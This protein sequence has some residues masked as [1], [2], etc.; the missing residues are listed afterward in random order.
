VNE[1]PDDIEPTAPPKL[2][3]L[4][5]WDLDLTPPASL[6]E[7]WDITGAAQ[8]APDNQVMIRVCAAA[9]GV[10]WG[11]FRRNGK[12]P[13]YSGRV[14]DYGG[15]VLDFCLAGG[16][17]LADIVTAGGYALDL[18]RGSLMSAGDV[19][20]AEDFTGARPAGSR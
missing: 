18:V 13:K 6:A 7:R 15:K 8:D 1:L 2:S 9:L 16:A 10:S 17:S 3:K 14:L 12:A 11:R 5:G 20:E 4:M 19:Q